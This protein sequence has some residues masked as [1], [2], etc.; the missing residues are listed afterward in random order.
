MWAV[1]CKAEMR[2]SSFVHETGRHSD[3]HVTVGESASRGGVCPANGP[4]VI[5]V[6]T[7][8]VAQLCSP[9]ARW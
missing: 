5:E 8:P 7:C 4:D 2:G 9:V 1:F 3:R 6:F